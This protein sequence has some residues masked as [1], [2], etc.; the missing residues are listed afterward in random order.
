MMAMT[1]PRGI[2]MLMPLSTGRRSYVKLTSASLTRGSDDTMPHLLEKGSSRFYQ[3]NAIQS[4]S[5]GGRRG[6]R[7]DAESEPGK[8]AP[9][10]AELPRRRQDAPT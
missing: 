3:T 10:R 8:G 1:L 5:A 7:I 4:V 9:C 6:G 2:S